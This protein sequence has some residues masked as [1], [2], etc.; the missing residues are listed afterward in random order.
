MQAT[1]NNLETKCQLVNR[2]RGWN[3]KID[4]DEGD[5]V[6][7]AAGHIRILENLIEVRSNRIE[8]IEKH[9]DS[10]LLKNRELEIAFATANA[11]NQELTKEIKKSNVDGLALKDAEIRRLELEHQ[12][13]NVHEALEKLLSITD[14]SIQQPKHSSETSSPGKDIKDEL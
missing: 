4:S 9:L 5:A 13:K 11:Q 12:F 6:L 8:E 1:F 7:W 3:Y 10:T 14:I 2:T